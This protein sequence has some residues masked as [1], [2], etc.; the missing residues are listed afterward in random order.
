MGFRPT[1]VG[2]PDPVPFVDAR[3][4]STEAGWDPISR[5]T[6]EDTEMG[7]AKRRRPGAEQPKPTAF[8]RLATTMETAAKASHDE[9]PPQIAAIASE[10]RRASRDLPQDKAEA[11]AWAMAD[12]LAEELA[13]ALKDAPPPMP[14]GDAR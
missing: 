7:E 8:E 4:R 2:F 11:A 3:A 13:A 1:R 10:L 12:R 14:N 9:C 6:E 5:L